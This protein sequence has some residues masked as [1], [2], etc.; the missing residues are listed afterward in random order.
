MREPENFL[1]YFNQQREIQLNEGLIISSTAEALRSHLAISFPKKFSELR[2]SAGRVFVTLK[3]LSVRGAVSK[4]AN[5]YGFFPS[6]DT[7]NQ[8]IFEPK[9]P[10]VIFKNELPQFTYHLTRERNLKNILRIGL[11][12]R[13]SKTAFKHPGNRIYLFVPDTEKSLD[14]FCEMMHGYFNLVG[15][16]NTVLLK[17]LV[18]EPMYY[19]DYSM[20]KS[21]ISAGSFSIFTFKNIPPVLLE[22]V[23]SFEGIPKD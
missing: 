4:E 21:N 6:K 2:I 5:T 12:P 8:F 17:V 10:V 13:E 9:F 14:E 11:T 19:A 16:T 23:K 3:D 22:P 15:P 18:S 1:E 7:G 20:A